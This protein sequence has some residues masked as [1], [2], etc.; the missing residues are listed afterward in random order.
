MRKTV[1]TTVI[2]ATSWNRSYPTDSV[3]DLPSEARGQD[4]T[5]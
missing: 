3:P 2:L 5:E 1:Q 4:G